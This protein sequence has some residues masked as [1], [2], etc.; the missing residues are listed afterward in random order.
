MK[1]SQ[2]T[3]AI[4]GC[5]SETV[6]RDTTGERGAG[7][8]LMVVRKT[9]TGTSAQ[10][11]GQWQVDGKRH[12]LTVG[13]YPDMT[14]RQA[15]VVFAEKVRAPRL[16]GKNP[17]TV[18]A[19][20]QRPTVE[21]LFKSYVASLRA[22]G[23]VS[24][25]NFEFTLLTGG[26]NCA[27]GIGRHKLAGDVT[28][29][30]VVATLR[31]WF[32]RG[33]RRQ[34][35]IARANMQS[36]FNHGLKSANSYTGAERFDW[37]LTS[38]PAAVVERDSEASHARD[39]NLS[40]EELRTVWH[41]LD[42]KGFLPDTA[43]A[44]RLMILCGQ[45]VRETLRAD[46]ADFD[47]DDGVWRMPA[48]KTKGGNPHALPLPAQALEVVKRLVERHGDGPLFPA[49]CGKSGRLG[50]TSLNL[51]LSRWAASAEFPA[52]QPRDLRRTW[53]SRTHDAGIDRFTRDLIQQHAKTDIST[54][55]YDRADYLEQMREAMT[56]WSVWLESALAEEP[57]RTLQQQSAIEAQV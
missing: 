19:K 33:C 5:T 50:D 12:K 32:D 29:G 13:R 36:A 25:D 21:A 44:I 35:D 11:V 15:R 45:R 14:L 16:T 10:W 39:R 56:K 46:G 1:D 48:H 40:A 57:T 55:H 22:A 9:K 54:K 18:A 30:D 37:G 34:A 52:F 7:T 42:G 20:H 17:K 26:R 43:D 27:D 4:K 8:L 28:P 47:L 51:A 2:I 49:R 6:L 23:K 31:Q 24:A 38:N 3:A 53:K 41:S